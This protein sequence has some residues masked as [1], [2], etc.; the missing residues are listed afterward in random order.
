MVSSPDSCNFRDTYGFQSST[1]RKPRKCRN[2]C[3]RVV[4]K[5]A[6]PLSSVLDADWSLGENA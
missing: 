3:R 6:P 2:D 5:R 1:E 4:C